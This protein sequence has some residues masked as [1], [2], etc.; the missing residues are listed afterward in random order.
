MPSKNKNTPP[1][2]ARLQRIVAASG[3]PHSDIARRAGVT[4]STVMKLAAGVGGHVSSVDAVLGALADLPAA[5][6]DTP[7]ITAGEHLAIDTLRPGIRDAIAL[8]C[9]A[10]KPEAAHARAA[11]FR[12]LSLMAMARTHAELLGVASA[13]TLPAS[14]AVELAMSPPAMRAAVG[15]RSNL[16]QVAGDFGGMVADAV[17]KIAS[18]AY[19]EFEPAWQRWCVRGTLRDFRPTPRVRISGTSN[20]EAI[21][22]SGEVKR[23]RLVDGQVVRLLADYG[24]I[25]AIGREVLINDD[26]DT[27][28]RVPRMQARAARRLEDKLAIEALTEPADLFTPANGND[29]TGGDGGTVSVAVMNRVAQRLFDQTD[30]SGS[31]MLGL[32]PAFA[33][34]PISMA[35]PAER[36]F[37]AEFNPASADTQREPNIWKDKVELIVSPH[38][39]GDGSPYWYA[40]TAPAIHETVEV[41]FLDGEEGPV[42]GESVDFDTEGL[43]LKVRH[44]V[45]AKALCHRGLVRIATGV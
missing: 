6:T 5:G 19:G 13:P 11:D 45:G 17:T 33:L 31:F 12:G 23:H 43:K 1:T 40:T 9:G 44:T 8:R 36:F 20:L 10:I 39:P 14:A 34:V 16:Y 42:F 4:Q 32:R 3:L 2:L 27:L 29:L 38:I 7:S 22:A 30:E 18:R 37:L 15:D 26:L 25:I 24:H 41:S 28:A 35:G 21:P